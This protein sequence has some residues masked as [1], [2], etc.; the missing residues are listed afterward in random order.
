MKKLKIGIFN[1]FL[2][3]FGGGEKDTCVMAEALSEKYDVELVSPKAVPKQKLET[4]LNVDLSRVHLRV[5]REYSN[6]LNI[7]A[8]GKI[9]FLNLSRR[10]DIFVNLVN[11][12]SDV[13]PAFAKKNMLRIQ[14]PFDTPADYDAP[15]TRWPTLRYYESFV[16][17]SKFTSKWVGERWKV[18]S[19]VLYPPA[20]MFAQGDKQKIILSVGRFFP[21][22]HNK[23]HLI[24]IS[25]FKRLCDEGLQGWEYHLFGSIFKKKEDQD[26][27]DLIKNFAVGYP[28]YFHENA[29][30]AELKEYFAKA[31][32]FLHA[33]GYGEDEEKAPEKFEHFGL[34]T[35]E[36]MSAGCVPIVING[37]GQKEIVTHGGNGFLW[38]TEK[39]MVKYCWEVIN[40]KNIRRTLSEAAVKDS[41]VFGRENFKK[42]LTALFDRL[43]LELR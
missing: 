20:E 23:K 30:F 42:K 8:V 17:N 1:R 26:Y 35:V 10:Y 9:Y 25:A 34:T 31:S 3:T 18:D 12:L 13:V 16:A 37:G 24:T 40:D 14:F 28:V 6:P 11:H 4:R 32:I 2:D 21:G 41:A 7:K 19:E 15:V 5:V 29:P 43:T 33:T 38:L 39:E 36:A 22:F 27:I